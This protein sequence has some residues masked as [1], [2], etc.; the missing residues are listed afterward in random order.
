[1]LFPL[2]FQ[3]GGGVFRDRAM[4]FDSQGLISRLPIPIS[5]AAC[6]IGIA[7]IG[8][9]RHAWPSVAVVCSSFILMFVVS[10]IT[11]GG[12]D[13]AKLITLVQFL[14]PM[15]ALVLGRLYTGIDEKLLVLSRVFLIIIWLVIPAQFVCS[16]LLGG[17]SSLWPYLYIFSIYQHLQYVPVVFA[18]A[19]VVLFFTL[20]NEK[21]ARK[22]IMLSLPLM[23]LY[24]VVTG[25]MVG[26]FILLSGVALWVYLYGRD[27]F[28][29]NLLRTAG[30]VMLAVAL[31]FAYM[32]EFRD[33][34]MSKEKLS[35]FKVNAS[36][37]I[38][39]TPLETRSV[40]WR[41]YGRAV[42]GNMG[43]FL[44]GNAG[45]PD[46]SRYSSAH[47]YYLDFLYHFGILPF[48]PLLVLMAA[49]LRGIWRRRKDIVA[50]P[51]VMGLT[52]VVL[53]LLFVE[54]MLKVGLRQ[55]YPGIFTFFLWGILT[56][57][58]SILSFKGFPESNRPGSVDS[59]EC[60]GLRQGT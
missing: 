5:V 28:S 23:A 49:T 11:S 24:L 36:G 37:D 46:R 13:P 41:V 35:F 40:Y 14:L 50:A 26:M 59:A 2:F 20:G 34:S 6:L 9:I 38:G 1:M 56:S 8:R 47:N 22:W 31:V 10:V 60:T 32:Y 55:P 12:V 27:L 51:D 43:S 58:L 4:I 21:S 15:V 54:N 17:S 16:W 57:R 44:V 29:R 3:P 18:S 7:L 25:T 45:S 33:Y 19:F 48:I 39:I 30:I 42:T 52:V 53:I